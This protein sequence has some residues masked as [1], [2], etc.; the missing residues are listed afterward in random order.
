[1][2]TSGKI[3]GYEDKTRQSKDIRVKSKAWKYTSNVVKENL[4]D[5]GGRGWDLMQ[6]RHIKEKRKK[7]SCDRRN[8]AETV[9]MGTRGRKRQYF[10]GMCAKMN[11]D[12]SIIAAFL[13]KI[14]NWNNFKVNKSLISGAHNSLVYS[15]VF[16]CL[17]QVYASLLTTSHLKMKH[18][19]QSSYCA[20]GKLVYWS[21][22]KI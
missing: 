2:E 3:T 9:I 7:A 10:N 18:V 13:F 4:K 5:R 6:Q 22:A 20:K 11:H 21:M 1:M 8:T 15:N 14:S 16:S 17:P 12:S 19:K